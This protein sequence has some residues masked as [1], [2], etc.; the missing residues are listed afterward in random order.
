MTYFWQANMVY[1]NRLKTLFHQHSKSLQEIINKPSFFQ[2]SIILIA[3]SVVYSAIAEL[4]M[5]HSIRP[6][7]TAAYA[8]MFTIIWFLP[9][10]LSMVFFKILGKKFNTESYMEANALSFFS[11]LTL[12]FLFF[13]IFMIYSNLFAEPR[14]TAYF[15]IVYCNQLLP[16]AI[17]GAI[18]VIMLIHRV[19][20]VSRL[21]VNAKIYQILLIW[22]AAG[23]I[24]LYVGYLLFRGW[25]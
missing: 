13:S 19:L 8:L 16:V 9:T 4:G 12:L 21:I 10:L 20:R 5:F 7:F 3:A 14:R 24:T 17:F 1:L 11:A 2:T 15:A 25:L 6:H 18:G 23:V 22:L